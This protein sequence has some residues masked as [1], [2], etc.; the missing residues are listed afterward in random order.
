LASVEMQRA[1]AADELRRAF[2]DRES[3]MVVLEARN[4]RLIE[5]RATEAIATAEMQARLDILAAQVLALEN[6]VASIEGW[7]FSQATVQEAV[8]AAVVDLREQSQPDSAPLSS[9]TFVPVTPPTFSPGGAG[10]PAL[11][12]VVF[13]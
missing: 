2:D 10:D 13:F 8:V 12:G 6:Y 5:L 1:V 11:D 9:E 3:R 4:V 7:T